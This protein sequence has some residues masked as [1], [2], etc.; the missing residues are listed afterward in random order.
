MFDSIQ[1]GKRR[2]KLQSVGEDHDF[3]TVEQNVDHWKQFFLDLG[4]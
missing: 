4:G 2:G 1:F 3:K